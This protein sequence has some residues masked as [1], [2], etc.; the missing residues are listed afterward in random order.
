[1]YPHQAHPQ[2]QWLM[3]MMAMNVG[4]GVAAVPQH[5]FGAQASSSHQA[6]QLNTR[7]GDLGVEPENDDHQQKRARLNYS[8]DTRMS[9]PHSPPSPRPKSNDG[10]ATTPQVIQ[11]LKSVVT[12]G[13]DW[14]SPT[15]MARR[16]MDWAAHAQE[17]IPEN[18]VVTPKPLAIEDE[19]KGKKLY[20]FTKEQASEAAEAVQKFLQMLQGLKPEKRGSSYQKVQVEVTV[21]DPIEKA[22]ILA[23]KVEGFHGP[24]GPPIRV[25]LLEEEQG[26]TFKP[27]DQGNRWHATTKGDARLFVLSLSIPP[28]EGTAKKPTKVSLQL[29]ARSK[30]LKVVAD[31]ETFKRFAANFIMLFGKVDQVNFNK[32]GGAVDL[33]TFWD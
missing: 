24:N 29:R 23:L 26:K 1:M 10:E 16:M 11:K 19:S 5:A 28:E 17:S 7:A 12:P 18:E 6:N 32:T 30:E 14:P 21:R 33:S 15:T 8:P 25:Q 3:Q 20:H 27:S 2:W 22:K 31:K 4:M 13:G 9:T